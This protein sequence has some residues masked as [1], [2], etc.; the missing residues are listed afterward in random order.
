MA[1]QDIGSTFQGLQQY[2]QDLWSL[3]QLQK[4]R[5]KELEQQLSQ[6]AAPHKQSAVQ[7]AATK[8]VTGKATV[9]CGALL[10]RIS[11]VNKLT[12]AFT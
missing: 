3:I 11:A 9:S 6:E 1:L 8:A 7:E 4:K 2:I 5:I 12:A 10:A